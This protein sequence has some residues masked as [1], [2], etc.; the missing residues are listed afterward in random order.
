MRF[1]FHELSSPLNTISLGINTLSPSE[2]TADG[3]SLLEQ[4]RE[5]C[6][7]LITSL[8]DIREV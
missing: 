1:V 8:K 3:V 7:L 5:N 2:L 6:K 4:T